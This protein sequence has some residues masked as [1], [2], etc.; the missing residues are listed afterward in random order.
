MPLEKKYSQHDLDQ[1]QRITIVEQ[2]LD[3]LTN[4]FDTRCDTIEDTLKSI[5]SHQTKSYT[6][7]D[8]F[9]FV[10]KNYKVVGILLLILIGGDSLREKM[11]NSLVSVFT[12]TDSKA[13]DVGQ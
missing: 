5:R 7:K 8:A 12:T 9:N 13:Q 11:F 4:K 3:S 2:K 10:K 6:I 1:V